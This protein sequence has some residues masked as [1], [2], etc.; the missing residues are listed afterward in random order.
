MLFIYFNLQFILNIFND[1]SKYKSDKKTYVTLGTFDGVHI[2]HQK[3]IQKLLKTTLKSNA[4]SV[5]LTFFPHP[6]IVLQK[7]FDIK[8]INTIE[9]RTMLLE[10]FGL[11]N[12]IVQRFSKKFSKLTALEFVRNILVNKLNIAK[13]IVGFKAFL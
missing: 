11:E 7:D 8:L 6:R 12:L 10:R 1:L 9:E 5:L 4:E 13:L 2:G 3:V